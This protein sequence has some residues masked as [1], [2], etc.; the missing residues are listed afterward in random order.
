MAFICQTAPSQ[1]NLK[2][3]NLPNFCGNAQIFILALTPSI[4][5]TTTKQKQRHTIHVNPL[6]HFFFFFFL[7]STKQSN[8][9]KKMQR[10]PMGPMA[11]SPEGV[12]KKKNW[13][14]SD[15]KEFLVKMT[16]R[17]A[18]SFFSFP[19]SS[20]LTVITQLRTSKT[21][22]KGRIGAIVADFLWILQKKLSGRS[23]FYFFFH[24]DLPPKRVDPMQDSFFSS[25]QPFFFAEKPI[26][27]FEN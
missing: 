7:I 9:V 4:T 8:Q 27:Y 2:L 11:S 25:W 19:P 13:E 1:P 6:V 20:S 10:F 22:I 15:K 12:R 24:V 21:K 3:H 26:F 23:F 5:T 17:T 14:I 16:W 18:A